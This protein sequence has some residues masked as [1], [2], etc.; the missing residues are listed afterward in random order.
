MYIYIEYCGGNN[1]VATL[2]KNIVDLFNT[3]RQTSF[4]D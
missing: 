3:A 1:T 4:N 2:K